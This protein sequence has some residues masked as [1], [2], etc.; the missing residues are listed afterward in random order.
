[1]WT[2]RSHAWLGLSYCC[3]LTRSRSSQHFSVKFDRILSQMLPNEL[4]MEIVAYAVLAD[5]THNSLAALAQ[6][7]HRLNEM[8][9]PVI[10]A[11][12]L[13]AIEKTGMTTNVELMGPD[14][15][16]KGSRTSWLS[17]PNFRRVDLWVGRNETR[18]SIMCVRYMLHQSVDIGSIAI[19]GQAAHF[20]V[21]NG[22]LNSSVQCSKSLTLNG[23]FA[24]GT[25]TGQEGGPFDIWSNT[26]PNTGIPGGSLKVI[27]RIF[28]RI[29]RT[30]Q[31]TS[32]TED[33]NPEESYRVCLRPA[34]H[35][36]K[37]PRHPLTLNNM[38]LTTPSLFSPSLYPWTLHILNHAPL[39]RLFIDIKLSALI[40]A[41]IL[42]SITAPSLQVFILTKS[43]LIGFDDLLSFLNRH[44][45]LETLELEQPTSIGVNQFLD[46]FSML[47]ALTSLHVSPLHFLPLFQQF[48]T[49]SFPQLRTIT[50]KTGL[51]RISHLQTAG[52]YREDALFPIFDYIAQLKTGRRFRLQL[53]IWC[54]TGLLEWIVSKIPRSSWST[55]GHPCLSLI[56]GISI[57]WAEDAAPSNQLVDNAVSWA[58]N[59]D[60]IA[61]KEK[62]P[63]EPSIFFPFTDTQAST[64]I[65]MNQLTYV[66]G[67]L[68][69][70]L[71]SISYRHP[72]GS[73]LS[74]KQR[75]P[76]STTSN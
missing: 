32:P 26:S 59:I 27:G 68:C 23:V 19:Q 37:L 52:Q 50:L 45:K 21:L 70:N 16:W 62:K 2:R 13:K 76:T 12:M 4:W 67:L 72:D 64:N 28:G 61:K 17:T 14:G 8:G 35:I 63:G 54:L 56:E 5:P 18:R 55:T 44:P 43:P 58:N 49:G 34:A 65:K 74:K 42:P 1:M 38:D 41:N 47:P 24:Y 48:Q 15:I 71:N 33:S 29:A 60:T 20:K 25:A 69:P 30:K 51:G 6:T 22:L 3:W 73:L 9:K 11:H 75:V 7:C 31:T 10:H 46:T 66:L 57:T 39:T 40:W 36:V 53:T